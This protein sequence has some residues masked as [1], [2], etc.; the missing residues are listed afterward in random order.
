MPSVK[1]HVIARLE[2]KRVWRK[3]LRLLAGKPLVVHAFEAAKAA[4]GIDAVYLN[5]ESE[6][7]AGLAREHG[8]GVFLRE[9]WL[10][11]DDV[12]LDQTTYAFAKAHPADVIGM[13][14]PVC[15]L[16]TA[17]DI[18]AGL[19][20]FIEGGF[21]TLL[22][23]RREHLHAFVGER[24]VNFEPAGKIP[25]TQDLPPVEL[26]SWN[27]CFWKRASF[28]ESY[29]SRGY[30]VF[31]GKV[32]LHPLD[33]LTAVKISDESDFRIAEAILAQRG[34][35]PTKATFWGDRP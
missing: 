17:Q 24:A 8:V 12:V 28:L 34:A 6:L 4:R 30:G 10:A 33:K 32:G 13:V 11:A 25:M 35:A 27:F 26:V 20:R 29:E 14:N 18:T 16:T 23:V 7:L 3:N 1:V 31:S 19:Q 9:P 22:T 2:S 15:P 21:D 5:T